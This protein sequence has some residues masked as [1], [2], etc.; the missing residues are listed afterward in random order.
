MIKSCIDNAKEY[1]QQIELYDAQIK[2]K[3]D[4]IANL[5]SMAM[6]VTATLRPDG[7]SPSGGVS[8][9]VGNSVAKIVDMQQE[10]NRDIDRFIDYKKEVLS[11]IDKIKSPDE[12]R[13]LHLRYFQYKPWEEIAVIMNY[14]YRNV[15]YIHSR[16]LQSVG[17]LLEKRCSNGG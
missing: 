16:A 1:L 3:C 2:N 15:C 8:D 7:G 9:K 10:I 13:L 6:S 12:I 11:L 5:R 14:T 4:E 17:K